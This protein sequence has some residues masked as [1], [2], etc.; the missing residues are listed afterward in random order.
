VRW[1]KGRWQAATKV[2]GRWHYLG[3]FRD[4]EEAARAVDCVLRAVCGSH[5]RLNF[6]T[7]LG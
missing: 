6:P 3:R 2:D 5:A 1:F 4:E 7:V